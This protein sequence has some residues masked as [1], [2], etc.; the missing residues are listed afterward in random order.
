MMGDRVVSSSSRLPRFGDRSTSPA[1]G[2]SSGSSLEDLSSR[3]K[4]SQ[5]Q[6]LAKA[7]LQLGGEI[8][9]VH[10]W[11]STLGHRI[12]EVDSQVQTV[13]EE[14]RNQ[15]KRL[16]QLGTAVGDAEAVSSSGSSPSRYSECLPEKAPLLLRLSALERGQR[17]VAAAAQR[18][19]QMSME[20]EQEQATFRS[21]SD[22]A[23]AAANMSRKV[24]DEVLA[25][26]GW[27]LTINE[28]VAKIDMQ[29]EASRMASAG[30]EA[31]ALSARRLVDEA[32]KARSVQELQRQ[33]EDLHVQLGS[34]LIA[35]CQQLPSPSST[36][37]SFT[38]Q[39]PSG[40]SHGRVSQEP[41]AEAEV[42]AW[43]SARGCQ[44]CIS[45]RPSSLQVFESQ[46]EGR[47]QEVSRRVDSLT[48]SVDEQLQGQLPQALVQSL[49]A[50]IGKKIHEVAR[51]LDGLEACVDEKLQ[52]LQ[53][54]MRQIPE[55]TAQHDRVSFQVAQALSK[56]ESQEMRLDATRTSFESLQSRVERL[57]RVNSEP[58]KRQAEQS[59]AARHHQGDAAGGQFGSLADAEDAFLR[60]VQ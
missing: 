9:S 18:A 56:A 32:A 8:R 7:L 13:L 44:N 57:L 36:A 27:Q 53:Q 23:D 38:P 52:K 55:L 3:S 14:Q 25:L 40:G 37:S 46:L 29:L 5:I 12:A 26:Q 50:Q 59:F 45:G 31:T 16:A 49:E 48:A 33:V 24:R 60:A 2:N 28:K 58:P 15:S 47:L 30:V 42:D 54:V 51:R 39:R 41:E 6:V 43:L 34:C 20:A 10:G 19:L 21:R 11:Q 22:A 35:Q 4:D 17:A 1:R